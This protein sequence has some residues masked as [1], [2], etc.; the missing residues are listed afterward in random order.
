MFLLAQSVGHSHLECSGPSLHRHSREGGENPGVP[1]PVVRTWISRLRENDDRGSEPAQ[2]RM[3]LPCAHGRQSLRSSRIGQSHRD[4]AWRGSAR[5]Q[6]RQL[7]GSAWRS[8]L[9]RLK[10]RR[11]SRR[12]TCGCFADFSSKLGSR[13]TGDDAPLLILA[14]T[15]GSDRGFLGTF[16]TILGLLSCYRLQPMV[17]FS[18]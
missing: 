10:I 18:S 3:R 15:A 13:I 4:R 5:T 17:L 7:P 12:R 2:L 6:A 16:S 9:S 8:R 14:H 11:Q 1:K